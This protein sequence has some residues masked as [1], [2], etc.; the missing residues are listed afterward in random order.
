MDPNDLNE[1][2]QHPTQGYTPASPVR[3]TMAWIGIVYS[4]IM[5][6]LTTFFFYTGRM[7]GNLAPLLSVPASVGLGILCL[8]SW[9]STG[10][11]KKGLAWFLAGML[12]LFAAL[13]LPI[14]IAG[15]LSNF[16]G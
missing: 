2:E 10:S 16:G 12:F 14:G 13:T 8:V 3:R 5:L 4:L 15:L 9:K 11:P 6:A 1:Q 7:L